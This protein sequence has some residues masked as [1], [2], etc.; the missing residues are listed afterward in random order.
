M[1]VYTDEQKRKILLLS[2]LVD[3]SNTLNKE[4]DDGDV[5]KII[6]GNLQR[7]KSDSIRDKVELLLQSSFR[8]GVELGNL[9]Q[10]GIEV[11]FKE[12]YK[13]CSFYRKLAYTPQVMFKIGNTDIL[14]DRRSVVVTSLLGLE[15][16][17]ERKDKGG[18]AR[19]IFI[20][21]RGFENALT[22]TSVRQ[23][24]SN[25]IITLVSDSYHSMANI[26]SKEVFVSGS[27][28]MQDL[29]RR[30]ICLSA[31]Y[32]AIVRHCLRG[33]R[34]VIG[35]SER[36]V[37]SAVIDRLKKYKYTNV[38]IYTIKSAPRISQLPSEW[39]VTT[40]VS[41]SK[42]SQNEQERQMKK[43]AEMSKVADCGI[44]V[45]NPAIVNRYQNLQ[46]SSGTLRNVVHML[47]REKKRVPVE[48]FYWINGKMKHK[49]LKNLDDLAQIIEK[50]KEEKIIVD[51]C[52][53]E[54]Q[55]SKALAAGCKDVAELKYEKICQK[56]KKLVQS[57]T[58][59]Q[60]EEPSQ[61]SPHQLSLFDKD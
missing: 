17:M 25:G 50:Y 52:D 57:I 38:S 35:D 15:Y 55:L 19:Y 21:D 45:F 47:S 49:I 6:S 56:Y 36:G 39:K 32:N 61:G 42:E 30:E 1:N 48:F 29:N 27:R 40:V 20:A 26:R 31:V 11:I 5:Q 41:D 60:K 2:D 33:E 58:D 43:D 10:R 22:N 14:N 59:L 34:I 12:Q 44:A 54:I 28:N 51:N 9:E 24:I 3:S 23:G 13:K 53:L 18:M 46:I 37:D 8:L 16:H 4:I 7:I